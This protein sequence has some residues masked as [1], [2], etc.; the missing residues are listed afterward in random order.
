MELVVDP[1]VH[2]GGDDAHLG[3]GVR[4]GMHPHLSHEERQQEDFVLLN[5][6]VL[7]RTNKQTVIQ[8]Y[9]LSEYFIV[10]SFSLWGMKVAVQH[11]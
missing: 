9:A 5:I 10:F 1:F 8:A 11:I 3:E 2:G 4:H 7:E 6:M